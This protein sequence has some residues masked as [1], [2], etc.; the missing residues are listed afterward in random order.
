MN[1]YASGEQLEN[2]TYGVTSKHLI[3]ERYSFLYKGL[4]QCLEIVKE[5]KLC[6]SK[7]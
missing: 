2:Q 7:I 1:N 4:K 5:S 6:K 3:G